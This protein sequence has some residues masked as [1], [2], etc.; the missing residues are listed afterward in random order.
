LTKLFESAVGAWYL[1]T[2]HVLYTGIAGG[3]FAASFDLDNL[4]A[5]PAVPVIEGVAPGE[6]MVSGE[7]TIGYLLGGAIQ[8]AG[9]GEALF[10]DR[11]G[12]AQPIDDGLEFDL[13]PASGIA[14]SPDGSLL[15]IGMQSAG[16]NNIWIKDLTRSRGPLSRLTFGTEG[17]IVPRWL[18]DGAS[19]AFTNTAGSMLYTKRADNIGDPTDVTATDKA[20][21]ASTWS[22]DGEWVLLRVGRGGGGRRDILAFRPGTDSVPAPLLADDRYDEISPDISPDGRWIAYASNESGRFEVYVRPFPDV[23]GGRWQVSNNSG[24]NPKWSNRGQELFYEGPTGMMAAEFDTTPTFRVGDLQ[25]LFALG[26]EFYG[27]LNY[28]TYDLMPDDRFVIIRTQALPDAGEMKLV[29]VQNWF[30]ELK[31]KMGN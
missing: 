15:A 23:Q 21:T 24:V 18:P 16:V 5:G 7:G 27:G 2:G 19:V 1:P 11:D 25:E 26:P 3:A 31:A 30:E 22:S 12:T 29:I 4:R 9:S 13:S 28:R 10:V 8:S 6:M 14:V 20:I 17:Q